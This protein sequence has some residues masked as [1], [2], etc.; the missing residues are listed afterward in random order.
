MCFGTCH[1]NKTM[2]TIKF[3]FL[4]MCVFASQMVHAQLN[5]V[6]SQYY[7]NQ[8][9]ANPAF[10][11]MEENWRLSTTLKSSWAGFE[12][13][14][15]M[16]SVTIDYGSRNNKVGVGL[17]FYNESAGLIQRT[18]LKATYAYHLQLGEGNGKFLDFGLSG[19]VM[20][21]WVDVEK[22]RGDNG[23]MALANFNQRKIYLDADF[24]LAYRM[25]NLTV[26]GTVPNLKRFFDRDMVRTVVDR[27]IYM[28]AA[29][30]KIGFEGSSISS[31]EPK[32]VYRGVE[33]FDNILDVGVNAMFFDSRLFLNGIYHSTRSTSL[34]L[35]TTYRTL[36]ILCMYTTNTA[37]LQNYANGDFEVGLKYGF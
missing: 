28:A 8:Y 6:G 34:G 17:N 29:S 2:K 31:I 22:L 36:S 35:G 4:G 9:I 19:G 26:Q 24:G 37:A 23:D 21:E 7:M 18:N 30:Y 1:L 3:A 16:Q 15:T 10:A 33:N 25:G 20:N 32:V 13:G 12:G 5:P 11:G 27:S 14:P